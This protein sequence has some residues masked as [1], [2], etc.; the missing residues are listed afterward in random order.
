MIDWSAFLQ[1]F[2]VSLGTTVVVAVHGSTSTTP[3]PRRN[4]RVT[5]AAPSS[6]RRRT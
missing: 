5:S 1:V 3:A 6:P 2:L 4:L